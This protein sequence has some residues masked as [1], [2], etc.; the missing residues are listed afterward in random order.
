MFLITLSRHPPR[1]GIC[2]NTTGNSNCRRQGNSVKGT[3]TFW[4]F[5]FS[6][7][8]V[9][10]APIFCFYIRLSLYILQLSTVQLTQS[11]STS[12]LKMQISVN[13]EISFK[14]PT[15]INTSDVCL[16]VAI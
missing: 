9:C 6:A 5:N 10:V 14:V 7:H 3:Q 11:E 8:N 13:T 1:P 12:L 4:P 15:V 16:C 2:S